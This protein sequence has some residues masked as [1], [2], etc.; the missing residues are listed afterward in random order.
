MLAVHPESPRHVPDV[1]RTG[2]R[3][4]TLATLLQRHR[5]RPALIEQLGLKT[6]CMKA[7]L[8]PFLRLT[9]AGRDLLDT[10]KP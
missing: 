3:W 6:W 1:L 2:V 8:M 10:V 9:Q 4:R 7:E 5:D